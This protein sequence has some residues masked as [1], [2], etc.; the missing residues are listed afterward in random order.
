MKL[1]VVL[2]TGSKKEFSICKVEVVV[3]KPTKS[4]DDPSNQLEEVQSVFPIKNLAASVKENMPAG[5]FVIKIPT[6]VLPNR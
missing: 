1:H 5:T 6:N 2:R 3:E 4:G